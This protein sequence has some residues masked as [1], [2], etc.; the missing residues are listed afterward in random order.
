M[1]ETTVALLA[2]VAVAAPAAAGPDCD[3]YC[4][5]GQ[6]NKA[7]LVMLEERQIVPPG[8]AR[9]IANGMIEVMAEQDA[10]GSARPANYLPFEKRLLEVA[11]AEASRLHTGRSRQDLHGTVRR[12]IL[13]ERLLD[14]YAGL[15]DARA[16]LLEVA[17]RHADVVI[18]AYTHGVPA[19]PTSMGHYLLAYSAAFERDAQRLEEAYTRHNKS[20][21]GAAALGTSGFALDRER[22]ARLLGFSGPV[23]NSYDA[24]LVSSA[25]FRVELAQVLAQSALTVTQLVQNVHT[26]YHNPVPWFLLDDSVTS[27]STIMPQK[28][29]PR[30]LDRL[31][32]AATYVYGDAHAITLNVHNVNTG[33]HDYRQLAPSLEHVDDAITMYER[34]ANVLLR[35]RVNEQR[36]LDEINLGYS[37]MTEVAD[38]LLRHADIPFRTAHHYAAELTKYGRENDKRPMDL[39]NRELRAVYANAVGGLLPID[40]KLI[41]AAMDPVEMV[42]NRK[43]LGGPQPEEVARM[44]AAHQAS[45][46]DQ[47]AWL[48]LQR[49]SLA[50]AGAALEAAFARIATGP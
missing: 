46:Q 25:D 17:T 29:N 5:M 48:G 28:R 2:L 21:L 30:P 43:G 9:T 27:G 47:R 32:S 15:L 13:R 22:L 1:H 26:Q 12:M 45:L 41:R 8:L 24:N 14:V 10:P 18:P 20:P 7:S 50:A 36:A 3:F 42:R 23:E 11:G 4:Y 34:Y 16:A 44:L 37:T 6:A 19:Q 35:L 40:V 39:S 31:R 49:Q 38:V 33:M